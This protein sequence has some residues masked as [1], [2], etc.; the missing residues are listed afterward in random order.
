[1]NAVFQGHVHATQDSSDVLCEQMQVFLNQPVS[2]NDRTR[3]MRGPN[4]T[5]ATVDKVVCD[6]AGQPGGVII[7]DTERNGDQEIGY[8]QIGASEVAM[9]KEER[10]MDAGR[11]N[12]RITQLG[13]KDGAGGPG[14]APKPRPT[15]PGPAKAAEQE[16]KFT[17]V[18]YEGRML[19]NDL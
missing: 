18:R 15:A 1:Q 9:Y 2:L 7:T 16:Y 3:A 12:V 10:K 11:G 19:V 6:A 8:K 4:A 17:W 5:P 13:P 14:A